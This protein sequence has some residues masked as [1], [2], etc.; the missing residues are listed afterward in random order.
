MFRHSTPTPTHQLAGI[1]CQPGLHLLACHDTTAVDAYLHQ[2]AGDVQ[3][4]RPDELV[5]LV[6]RESAL[7]DYLSIRANLFLQAD[8]QRAPLLPPYF[9]DHL[10]RLDQRGGAVS[11]TTRLYTEFYRHI[12][13]GR[14]LIL[15]ADIL[16]QLTTPTA[17][18]LLT[19]FTASCMQT[20]TSLVLLTSDANL[21]RD[22][23]DLVHLPP[24]H[25][26]TH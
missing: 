10:D 14:R 4:L 5:G 11:V 6:T 20:K 7:I 18:Q 24:T 1:M 12:L 8:R 19:D 16:Q 21:L 3:S 17:R 23:A 13:D 2:Y 15:M 9:T 25:L 22:H 26:W